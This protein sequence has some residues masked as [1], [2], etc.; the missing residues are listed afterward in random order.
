MLSAVVLARNEEEN[1]NRCLQ[2]LTFCDEIIVIDDNSTDK[3]VEIAKKHGATVYKRSLNRDFSSQRAY[4]VAKAKND[5]I[6]VVDADE[7]V[8]KGL[9]HE[10][11]EVVGNDNQNR[12]YYLRRRDHF[13]G[14]PVTHGELS[15]AYNQGFIRLFKKGAGEWRG[16]VH[17]TF[18]TAEPTGKLDHFIEHYP[19]QSITS[20]LQ[21]I[22]HYSTIRAEE[23]NHAGHRPSLREMLFYPFGKF[24]YTYFIKMGYKDGAAGFVYSFLM[25]FHSFLVRAKLD[26]YQEL[27]TTNLSSETCF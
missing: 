14:H 11:Q 9:Q 25:S 26:Q 17:E 12:A 7:E 3:T 6:L 20:F 27:D 1:I 22:N 18:M 10:I 19:H 16:E 21:E 5:W 13:W 2:S 15:S 8:S 4:A 24:I 23:L